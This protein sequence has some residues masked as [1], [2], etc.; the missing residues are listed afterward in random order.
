MKD[1]RRK[2]RGI[3]P[4]AQ[5]KEPSELAVMLT[6]SLRG[7]LLA[8]KATD[9]QVVDQVVAEG[10]ATGRLPNLP[11][12]RLHRLLV[13]ALSEVAFR[14]SIEDSDGWILDAV[15]LF[16]ARVGDASS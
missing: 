11:R 14:D 1:L 7:A 2:E 12:E 9:F 6:A 15:Q 13:F 4:R 5:I 16:L 3:Q 8:S 10:V